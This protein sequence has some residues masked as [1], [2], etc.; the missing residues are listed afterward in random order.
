MLDAEQAQRPD[1]MAGAPGCGFDNLA[2]R[3]TQALLAQ[4]VEALPEPERTVVRQ[5][6]LHDLLFSQIATMLGLS[7]GRVSQIH[8]SALS[9]LSKSM[10]VLR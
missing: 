5:H 9:R 2:W 3:Q 7:K 10:R 6:Y 4:R 8:K 1:G